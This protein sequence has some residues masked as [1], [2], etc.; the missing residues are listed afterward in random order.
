MTT[1]NNINKILILFSTEIKKPYFLIILLIIFVI[2]LYIT[3]YL[4][5]EI[6]EMYKEVDLELFSISSQP[7]P[8]PYKKKKRKEIRNNKI[9]KKFAKIAEQLT[10]N[11][12][13]KFS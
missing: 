2:G 8:Y 10:T 12:L 5:K 9:A 1:I 6:N 4:Y 11:I 3:Y 7:A 13:N